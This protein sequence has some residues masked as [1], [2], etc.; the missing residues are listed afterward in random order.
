MIDDYR[1]AKRRPQSNPNTS[2][3]LVHPVAS[4]DGHS[5]VATS[6]V[7]VVQSCS[8]FNRW[9]RLVKTRET[10]AQVVDSMES[11]LEKLWQASLPALDRRSVLTGREM[12][13]TDRPLAVMEK[14]VE[15]SE[16]MCSAISARSRGDGPAVLYLDQRDAKRPIYSPG[17]ARQ[18]KCLRGNLEHTNPGPRMTVQKITMSQEP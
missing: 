7:V 2:T 14:D 8:A 10:D 17:R 5:R 13:L 16:R 3:I 12:A 11:R 4:V 6:Q 15:P 9:L 18:R 1:G